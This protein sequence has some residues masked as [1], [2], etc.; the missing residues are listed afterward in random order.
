MQ[1][2]PRRILYCRVSELDD[3][4]H[5]HGL[6]RWDAERITVTPTD[7]MKAKRPLTGDNQATPGEGT[8]LPISLLDHLLT[9]AALV[10][11]S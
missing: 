9:L 10:C 1:W 7:L 5:P 4:C 8:G 2:G 3:A 6:R 11:F